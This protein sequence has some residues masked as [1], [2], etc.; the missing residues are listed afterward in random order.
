MKTALTI[1]GL[2]LALTGVAGCGDDGAPTDASEDDFC[3][4]LTTLEE[5]LGSFGE[6]PDVA[7]VV[8]V[9]KGIADDMVETG[10]PEDM[11]DDARE[12]WQLT[13]DAMQ[14][15]DDDASEE[16]VAALGSDF[17]DSDEEKTAAFDDYLDKT[18]DFQ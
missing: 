2:A 13:M 4:N 1:A 12:G 5:E 8:E 7:T 11:P 9:M 3:A 18:C 17:S 15:L 16:D 6:D 10:T 14:D